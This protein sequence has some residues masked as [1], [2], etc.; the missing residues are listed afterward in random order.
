M[1]RFQISEPARARLSVGTEEEVHG[2][3]LITIFCFCF[4][5]I[6]QKNVDLSLTEM[7]YIEKIRNTIR[8]LI[9]PFKFDNILLE[10]VNHG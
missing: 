5:K 7:F 4:V 9:N 1:G 10:V 8:D 2:T 3:G 6:S